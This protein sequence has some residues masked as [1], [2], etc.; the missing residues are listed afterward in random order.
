MKR[1]STWTSR[2]A[3]VVWTIL[4]LLMAITLLGCWDVLDIDQRTFILALGIDSTPS[5][6]LLVS[7][8]AV[9]ARNL[10]FAGGGNST[11]SSDSNSPVRVD[12]SVA[13][14]LVAALREQNFRN[15]R[16]F[17][18]GHMSVVVVGEE[19]A[20]THLE[21]VLDALFRTEKIDP[22]LWLVV[23]RGSAEAVIRATPEVE[24]IPA[25]FL[26]TLLSKASNKLAPFPSVRLWEAQARIMD[27]A[28]ELF[29]PSIRLISPD[30]LQ[31][32]ETAVFRG[33]RLVGFLSPEQTRILLWLTGEM[34]QGEFMIPGHE[35][36]DGTIHI[37][38]TSA[39]GKFNVEYHSGKP[40]LTAYLDI[41]ANIQEASRIRAHT[42]DD[43]KTIEELSESLLE[44]KL[45][46]MLRALQELGS[47]IVGYERLVR[48][49][50]PDL[51]RTLDW[52]KEF[53]KADLVTRVTVRIQGTGLT[54]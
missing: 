5:E 20:K 4:A 45:M 1:P 34:D 25:I 40:R 27:P 37:R 29:L 28:R 43:I 11:G 49:R 8:Q 33:G 15:S 3:V 52:D 50:T 35:P 26:S 17:E 36:K 31:M 13:P 47:D 19:A 23:S 21:R 7:T 10:P 42:S 16:L 30:Q 12:T 51:W 53:S 54:R 2:V 9:I 48:R 44:R 24:S 6:D 39:R 32:G 18:I 38:V 14:T 41:R 22:S 46:E